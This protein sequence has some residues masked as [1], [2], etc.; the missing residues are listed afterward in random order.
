[1]A[2]V[3]RADRDGPIE[4]DKPQTEIRQTPLDLPKGFEH[5]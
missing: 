1:M 3:R 2:I 4:E 5:V